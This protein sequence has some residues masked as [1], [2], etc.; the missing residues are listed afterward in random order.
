M[1]NRAMA[2]KVERARLQRIEL[3]NAEYL[4]PMYV[5]SVKMDRQELA[6]LCAGVAVK[7]CDAVM[8]H[9]RSWGRGL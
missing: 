7:K 2:A 8:V 4:K 1:A 9:R 3:G 6:T 5:G